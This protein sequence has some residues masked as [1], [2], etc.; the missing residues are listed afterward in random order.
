MVS[1]NRCKSSSGLNF[2][3]AFKAVLWKYHQSDHREQPLF[4][5]RLTPVCSKAGLEMYPIIP[6][7][8]RSRFN[9]SEIVPSSCSYSK[10]LRSFR[11]LSV[12]ERR[13]VDIHFSFRSTQVVN[14][15]SKKWDLG[16]EKLGRESIRRVLTG[17]STCVADRSSAPASGSWCGTSRT[18]LCSRRTASS[19]GTLASCW[20]KPWSR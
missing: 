13:V 1:C 14:A 10:S 20:E 9:S 12:I 3:Q 2:Q 15:S 19:A 4:L 16:S 8:A 5:K 17:S 18:F 6:M 7:T 11:E